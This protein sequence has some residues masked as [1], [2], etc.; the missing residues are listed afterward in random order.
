MAKCPSEIAFLISL[1]AKQSPI[2]LYL[3][4]VFFSSDKNNII[5]VENSETASYYF[6]KDILKYIM[7]EKGIINEIK[8]FYKTR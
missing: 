7:L 2:A 6:D 5:S 3:I 4:L 8:Y 1:G